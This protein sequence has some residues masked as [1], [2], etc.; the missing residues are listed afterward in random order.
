M[1]YGCKSGNL[2]LI[3]Y[4]LS[5]NEF[6]IDPRDIFFLLSMFLDFFY[7]VIL[8]YACKSGNPE[9]VKYMLSLSQ[10]DVNTKCIKLGIFIL[11]TF[12]CYLMAF[13]IICLMEFI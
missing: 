9:L 8:S 7:S 5:L 3:K 6:D 1:H 4:L 10:H 13:I 12:L 2:D 11:I